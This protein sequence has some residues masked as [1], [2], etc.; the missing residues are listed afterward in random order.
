VNDQNQMSLTAP[1]GKKA[2]PEQ[3][4]IFRRQARGC[5]RNKLLMTLPSTEVTFRLGMLFR[6]A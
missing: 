6:R 2:E 3:Q 5:L 1:M 4:P